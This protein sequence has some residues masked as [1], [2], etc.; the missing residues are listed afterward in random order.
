MAAIFLGLILLAFDRRMGRMSET[1]RLG[2]RISHSIR[3]A[4]EE[5][6][7]LC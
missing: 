3:F 7:D 1:S 2:C 4:L 5:N 6:V